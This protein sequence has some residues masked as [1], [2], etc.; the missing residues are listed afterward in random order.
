[1]ET[2]Y[3]KELILKAFKEGKTVQSKNGNEW[4]DF[5]PQ[6]QLD[7]PNLDYR[8]ID[9]W[10]I[11]PETTKPYTQT[12]IQKLEAE[13]AELLEALHNIYIDIECFSD[14]ESHGYGQEVES[15]IQKHKQ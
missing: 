4:K 14:V 11:K 13:K 12:Q 9:N 15:L 6:N 5:I 8:G 10:R 7:T 2:L 1:M 3:R